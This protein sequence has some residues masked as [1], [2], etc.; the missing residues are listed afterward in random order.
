MILKWRLARSFV[1]AC[2]WA[3]R[4]THRGATERTEKCNAPLA[5]SPVVQDVEHAAERSLD[6][7]IAQTLPRHT[8][9]AWTMHCSLHI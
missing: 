1:S 9:V 2:K 7:G 4:K 8:Y 3:K 5:Q 6:G